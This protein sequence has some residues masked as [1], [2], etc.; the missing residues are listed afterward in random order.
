MQRVRLAVQKAYLPAAVSICC[1][2]ITQVSSPAHANEQ[3]LVMAAHVKTDTPHTDD[4]GW[5]LLLGSLDDC[6]IGT[7]CVDDG[8][9]VDKPIMVVDGEPTVLYNGVEGTEAFENNSHTLAQRIATKADVERMKQEERED[10]GR[11]TFW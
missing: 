4:P 10:G 11:V 8:D 6:N 1:K 7:F 3:T 2:Q 5:K 9:L